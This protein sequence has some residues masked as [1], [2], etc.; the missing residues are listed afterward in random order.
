MKRSIPAQPNWI[1]LG[2]EVE[3]GVFGILA[4][5]K[6]QQAILVKVN[7][8]SGNNQ[9]ERP[10]DAAFTLDGKNI[11]VA[12][13]SDLYLLDLSL[14]CRR[15]LS[16]G[17]GQLKGTFMVSFSHSG[18]HMFITANGTEAPQYWIY[19]TPKL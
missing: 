19:R 6:D 11:I 18:E 12:T 2:P 14:S 7:D 3:P 10:L 13:Q 4:V 8:A 17:F 9:F 5:E 16:E 1:E 15:V